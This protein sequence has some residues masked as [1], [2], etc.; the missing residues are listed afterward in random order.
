[1]ASATAIRIDPK[2][3]AQAQKLAK[4]LGTNLSTIV[5]MQLRQFVRQ[6]RLRVGQDD[7]FSPEQVKYLVALK[8]RIATGEEEME[9][10]FTFEE[11]MQEMRD[12]RT[13][14][15]KVED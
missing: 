4:E 3:K 14:K 10:P 15:I 2:I 5:N 12:I 13:G 8:K 1:M 7:E 11:F 9:G 6:K